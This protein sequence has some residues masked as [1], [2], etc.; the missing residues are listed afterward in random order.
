MLASE[1]FLKNEKN[2]ENGLEET[3]KMF[4]HEIKKYLTPNETK[5]SEKKLH[6]V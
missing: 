6:S 3:K 1:P 5:K 4:T 2:K